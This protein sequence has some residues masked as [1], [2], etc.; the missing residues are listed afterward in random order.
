MP[1]VQPPGDAGSDDLAPV[2]LRVTGTDGMTGPVT[3]QATTL[4]SA[5]PC[6]HGLLRH[7]AIATRFCTATIAGRLCRSCICTPAR[8]KPAPLPRR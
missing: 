8:A 5:C 3:A 1:G 7:D 6:G 2:G 4:L